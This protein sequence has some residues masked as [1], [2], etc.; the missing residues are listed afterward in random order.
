[1]G[2]SFFKTL[3]D[4]EVT[5]ELKNDLKIRGVS[6][7]SDLREAVWSNVQK[8]RM[9]TMMAGADLTTGLEVDRP[10]PEPQAGRHTGAGGNQI[11]SPGMCW[12]ARDSGCELTVSSLALRMFSSEGRLR[13]TSLQGGLG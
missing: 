5:V 4:H 6:A 10:V 9:L 3:V 2:H 7:H 11:P 8:R 1:M 12:E 13:T